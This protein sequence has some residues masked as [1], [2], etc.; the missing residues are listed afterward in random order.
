MDGKHG[1]V[2][3]ALRAFAP[4]G[5]DAALVLTGGRPHA[6]LEQVKKGGRVAY[7]N[8]VGPEPEPAR[9]ITVRGYDGEAGPEA[10][11]H[12][13]AL[14]SR[15]RSTSRRNLWRRAQAHRDLAKHHLGKLALR[16][17]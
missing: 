17:R 8:G 9:G 6:A 15:A 12:L 5:L 4:Q 10:L 2:L 11:D 1:A 14:I 16:L 3:D 13:N 7:P